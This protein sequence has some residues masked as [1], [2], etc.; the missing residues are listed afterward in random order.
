LIIRVADNHHALVQGLKKAVHDRQIARR[1]PSGENEYG[2]QACRTGGHTPVDAVGLPP[3][4][5]LYRLAL[6]QTLRLARSVPGGSRVGRLKHDVLPL[7]VQTG[8]SFTPGRK[9]SRDGGFRSKS[10][11]QMSARLA[12]KIV[13]ARKA[14][15]GVAHE[16]Y[17]TPPAGGSR[18]RLCV[19]WTE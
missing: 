9:L 7:G 6:G 16:L 5:T 13:N 15:V 2:A 1:F 17:G 11:T 10:V 19:G 3:P 8:R 12:L 18:F 4:A 14:G